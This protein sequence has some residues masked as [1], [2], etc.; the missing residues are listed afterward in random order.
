MNKYTFLIL[1]I[2]TSI[3]TS[4]LAQPEEVIEVEGQGYNCYIPF[5]ENARLALLDQ[6]SNAEKACSTIKGYPERTSDIVL[7]QVSA[8]VVVAKSKFTCRVY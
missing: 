4:S 2:V 7:S 3:S 5:E 8:C 6:V 1:A